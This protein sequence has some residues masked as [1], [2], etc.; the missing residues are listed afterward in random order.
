MASFLK[1][2]FV[3]KLNIT[4]KKSFKGLYFASSQIYESQVNALKLMEPVSILI[5]NN[6]A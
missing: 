6:P 3:I 5:Y 1:R 4:A 2:F